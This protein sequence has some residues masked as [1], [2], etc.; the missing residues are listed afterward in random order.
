M[1]TN[2]K[3]CAWDEIRKISLTEIGKEVLGNHIQLFIDLLSKTL[4]I[5]IFT[6]Q[7][8]NNI[9]S[10]SNKNIIFV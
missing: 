6:L 8:I 5:Q 7:I 10:T 1:K 4:N 9:A 3:N 2:E